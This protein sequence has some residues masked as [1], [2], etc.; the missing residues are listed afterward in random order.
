MLRAIRPFQGAGAW[1]PCNHLAPEPHTRAQHII[2]Q[3]ASRTALPKCN[4]QK[5]VCRF[6]NRATRGVTRC[7]T[8]IYASDVSRCGSEMSEG[9]PAV[10]LTA[11]T[12]LIARRG[13]S[14]G[15][16]VGLRKTRDCR[17]GD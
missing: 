2:K 13:E 14:F 12:P 7:A 17:P 6:W 1:G 11:R 10:D 15:S 3:P 9:V 5:R 8:P 16:R 4:T